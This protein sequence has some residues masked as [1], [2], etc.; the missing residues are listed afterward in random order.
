MTSR[1]Q[2]DGNDKEAKWADIEDDEDD[3]AP[4]TIEWNDGTKITL[5]HTET[6]PPA[7]ISRV[8]TPPVTVTEAPSEEAKVAVPALRTT[9][10]GP[11]ATV[12]KLGANAE[13][14]QSK[15][16]LFAKSTGEKPSLS[17]KSSVPVPPKSPWA[18]LPPV[19]KV[20]PISA[21]AQPQQMPPRS[22]NRDGYANASNQM[23]PYQP[24]KEIAADDFNR[25]WRDG[26]QSNPRELFNSQSGRYEAVTEHR[27]GPSRNEQHFR[28]PSL[29]QR[30]VHGDPALQPEPS[31][32]FQTNRTHEGGHWG[33]RRTSSNVSGGSGFIGRRMSIDRHGELGPNDPFQ[34]RRGSMSNNVD[35]GQRPYQSARPSKLSPAQ[36]HAHLAD[37]SVSSVSSQQQSPSMSEAVVAD[38]EPLEDPVV[39]QQRVMREKIEL[40]RK[41]RQEQEEKEEAERKE[42]IRIKLEQMDAQQA[43]EQPPKTP[44]TAHATV[45]VE[46]PPKPPVLEAA[47]EPRQYGMMK[48]HPPVVKRS[49]S[50][51]E[52]QPFENFNQAT[53]QSPSTE[54]KPESIK[55]HSGQQTNGVRHFSDS[56]ST[57]VHADGAVGDRQ[58]SNWK[59]ASP[60]ATYSGWNGSRIVSHASPPANL[61]GPPTNNKSLGNG[62]FDRV[63]GGFNHGHVSNNTPSGQPP[64]SIVSPSENLTSELQPS[65]NTSADSSIPSAFLSSANN[66]SSP[67][68]NIPS[69]H[70]NQITLISRPNPIGTPASQ[71]RPPNPSESSNM[72]ATRPNMDAD[73]AEKIAGWNNFRLTAAQEKADIQAA[74]AAR[75]ENPVEPVKARPIVSTWRKVEL[76]DDF[77]KRRVVKTVERIINGDEE[78][79]KKPTPAPAALSG[80]G[81]IGDPPLGETLMDP[82][83]INSGRGSRF[84]PQ[85]QVEKPSNNLADSIHTDYIGAPRTPSP[86]PPMGPSHP[87]YG[88]FNGKITVKLPVPKPVV[89]LPGAQKAPAN[90]PVNTAPPSFASMAATPPHNNRGSTQ[91]A[92]NKAW[93]TRIDGLFG[94]KNA[95]DGKYV[96]EVASASK[97]PLDNV[98]QDAASV[99]LPQR[100]IKTLESDEQ[101]REPDTRKVEEIDDIFE[102]REAGSLPTVK[103]PF[104]APAAAWNPAPTPDTRNRRS[105]KSIEVDTYTAEDIAFNYD[106]HNSVRLPGSTITTN[107]PA[108]HTGFSHH[109]GH[110][111]PRRGGY[112]GRGRRGREASGTHHNTTHTSNRGHGW[113]PRSASTAL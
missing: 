30:P 33:R 98:H 104:T 91:A 110:T 50:G 47:S 4:E 45:A 1:L 59:S 37:P 112:R 41:R 13:R 29:L 17:L 96:I 36:V 18:T 102:D 95:S 46:S 6:Q 76:N 99:S 73:R 19:E 70:P 26:N 28:A 71:A 54:H 49:G 68:Q 109:N 21:N 74:F 83:P 94:K 48:V 44:S 66:L 20:S 15:S 10:V 67:H 35:H 100:V 25:S 32:G 89:R 39:V 31:P 90:V 61:W 53:P 86:P 64:A 106:G 40:A 87:V 11:N 103:V 82:V 57:E 108:R 60:A 55:S 2:D 8:D 12:L 23:P 62:T 38:N 65:H 34:N 88:M 14:H 56:R 58:K 3:W 93:Q 69:S 113:A 5:T 81:A 84:F 78:A 77:G 107:V 52:T 75:H 92:S 85:P 7:E 42:R 16:G 97:V 105:Q 79:D 27:R 80:F 43:L 111:G 22:F 9:T 63:V 51:N 72:F 24:A 101:S